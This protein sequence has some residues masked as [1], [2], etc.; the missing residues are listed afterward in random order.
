[1]THTATHPTRHDNRSDAELFQQLRALAEHDPGRE[2][3]AA[4][5]V[6]R[7]TWLVHWAVN[8]YRGRGEQTEELEQVGYLGLVEAIDRFD[9][10]RGVEFVSYARP[11]V[12]G[13]IRRHFRDRRRWVRLPRKIQDLK[14]QL[15]AATE[16][17]THTT[18]RTP[19]PAELAAHLDVDVDDVTEALATDDAFA[20]L[21][22]D[23]PF[24]DDGDASTYLDILID[25]ADHDLDDIVDS[26]ALWPL[27]GRLP[28]REQEMLLLRFYGNKTQSDIAKRLGISQMHVSRLL[29]QT[30]TRLRTQLTT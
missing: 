13:E 15:G 4:T 11:T 8:R 21:S 20:P 19:T 16:H 24:G 9:P 28:A 18:G 5:L 7:Y 27:I 29:Q 2:P 23:T 30:L 26:E 3:I 1:M 25:D 10:D 6:A 22:L 17:L 12:L 14:L